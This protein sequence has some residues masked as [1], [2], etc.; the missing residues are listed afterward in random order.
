MTIQKYL[1]H[2]PDKFSLL[3]VRRDKAASGLKT[4][5]LRGN[6]YWLSTLQA[7]WGKMCIGAKFVF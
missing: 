5:S 4:S 1:K 6:L 3:K 2:L 7:F